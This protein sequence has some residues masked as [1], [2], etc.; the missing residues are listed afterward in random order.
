MISLKA[1]SAVI[2]CGNWMNFEQEVRNYEKNAIEY[3]HVDVMDGTF[4]PNFMVGPDMVRHLHATTNIP[5]DIHLMAAKPEDKILWFP[6][7]EGDLFSFH[8]ETSDDPGRCI[9]VIHEQGGL[10]GISLSPDLPV[11]ALVPYMNELDFINVMCVRPGFAGQPILPGSRQRLE[12]VRRLAD[13]TGRTIYVQVD[14]NVSFTN[15]SWMSELGA[16]IFVAGTSSIYHKGGTFDDNVK[17]M[18]DVI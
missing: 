1:I 8:M 18:R 12:G 7:R 13:S 10:A 5:L 9:R 16:N 14:G 3:I 2:T 17:R 15:C 11:E 6:L 4:V